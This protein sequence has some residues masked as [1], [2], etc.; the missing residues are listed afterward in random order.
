MD[1]LRNEETT[2]ERAI[3]CGSIYL[4]QTDS[5]QNSAEMYVSVMSTTSWTTHVTITMMCVLLRQ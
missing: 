4:S 1:L 5:V 2:C 3:R